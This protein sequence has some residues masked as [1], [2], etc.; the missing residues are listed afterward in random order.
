MELMGIFYL[1]LGRK[2]LK[3]YKKS[4]QIILDLKIKFSIILQNLIKLVPRFDLL[5]NISA[6]KKFYSHTFF[7]HNSKF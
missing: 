3:I 2:N 6:P 1:D 7:S 5:N 4:I